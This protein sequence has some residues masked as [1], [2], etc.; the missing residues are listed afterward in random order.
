MT[1]V[2]YAQNFEDVMLMRA[3]RDIERG[4]YID[5]G[6]QG[7]EEGSVTR[8]FYE[9]G[10]SG[11]NIEPV[12]AYCAT[13]ESERPRD[14]NLCC[15]VGRENGTHDFYEIAGT[16]LSTGLEEIAEEYGRARVR[17]LVVPQRTLD[18]ICSRHQVETVHFLKVDVEG[19]ERDV[20]SGFSFSK[21]R[22]W[23]LL[24]EA[25]LPNSPMPSYADWEPVVLAHDYSFVWDDG[26]NRFYVANERRYLA[27]H[28]SKPPNYFDDFVHVSLVRAEDEA[29]RM[30][31][32]LGDA[33]AELDRLNRHIQGSS[34]ELSRLHASLSWR[35]T[36]PLRRVRARLG[37][38]E[39]LARRTVRRMRSSGRG[40]QGDGLPEGAAWIHRQLVQADASPRS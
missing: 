7:P 31:L 26:L 12:S 27:D 25:T 38:L 11:I 8:A 20:V 17:R 30:R 13:L 40:K 3:F 35:I 22:P 34:T 15:F 19:S 39:A 6:A 37:P 18:D 23:I 9:R 2:S 10:W 1:F 14:V 33:R 32:E 29:S 21:V 5:V 36:L 16:G 28:F 24:I 4:F